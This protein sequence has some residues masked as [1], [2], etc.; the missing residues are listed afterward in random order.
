MTIPL[1]SKLHDDPNDIPYAEVLPLKEP[2]GASGLG[3]SDPQAYAVGYKDY[4]DDPEAQNKP[5]GPV[6]ESFK[7]ATV[8][9]NLGWVRVYAIT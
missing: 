5:A 6:A 8:I 7:E 9:E 1:A 2:V 4:H 3:Y